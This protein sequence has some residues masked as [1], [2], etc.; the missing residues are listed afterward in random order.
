MKK[1]LGLLIIAL[2]L[3]GCGSGGSTST[4]VDAAKGYLEAVKAMDATKMNEFTVPEE[5]LTED[6]IKEANDALTEGGGASSK[7][8]FAALFKTDFT[9]GEA[10]IDGD[11]ATV[12][13]SWLGVNVEKLMS[14][15]MTEVFTKAMDEEFSAL[16]EEQQTSE[17]AKLLT[18]LVNKSTDMKDYKGDL[19]L[20]KVDGKWYAHSMNGE[21]ADFLIPV[22][23]E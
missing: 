7:E 13:V 10:V 17:M 15:Y 4:P 23:G 2:I 12:P 6:E 9:F 5:R 18:E 16:S 22:L 3:V 21:N 8:L 20:A 11:S 19:K 1:L 14:Q